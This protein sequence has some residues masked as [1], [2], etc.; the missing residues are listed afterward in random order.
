MS[1]GGRRKWA[2]EVRGGIADETCGT[3]LLLALAQ[4]TCATHKRGAVA[5]FALPRW[6]RGSGIDERRG[7]AEARPSP[8]IMRRNCEQSPANFTPKNWAS[9]TAGRQYPRAASLIPTSPRARDAFR[10]SQVSVGT[11]H[12]KSTRASG[13]PWGGW[14]PPRPPDKSKCAKGF[15]R[16]PMAPVDFIRRAHALSFPSQPSERLAGAARCRL[17]AAP[18]HAIAL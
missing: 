11:Q 2:H 8:Q 14:F 5:A 17:V 18:P 6:L 9:L 4:R 10:S 7:G 1:R 12:E 13:F 3:I 16:A 15:R